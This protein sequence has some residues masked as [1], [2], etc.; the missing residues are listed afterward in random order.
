MKIITNQDL[1]IKIKKVLKAVIEVIGFIVAIKTI[2][3]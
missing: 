1:W 3:S 2:L